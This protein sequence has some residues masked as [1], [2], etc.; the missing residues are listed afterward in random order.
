[1]RLATGWGDIL[2]V[3]VPGF[4]AFL[5]LGY[6]SEYFAGLIAW[7]FGT[8]LGLGLVIAVL[9]LSL[10]L[11]VVL[12]AVR[13]LVL[14][15]LVNRRRQPF[16]SAA[17]DSA[18]PGAAAQLQGNLCLA[19]AFSV[20]MKV[21]GAPFR[22]DDPLLVLAGLAACLALA[23]AYRASLRAAQDPDRG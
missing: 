21:I 6:V 7:S 17:P 18:V 3:L 10:A 15:R 5:G 20:A 23:L 13:D 9:L 16:W 22:A 12:G 11:G 8:E 4:V 14:D 19:V 1:M 2:A